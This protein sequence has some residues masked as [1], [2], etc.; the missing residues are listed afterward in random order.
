VFVAPNI[1]GL[2]LTIAAASAGVSIVELLDAP[3][4]SPRTVVVDNADDDDD[5]DATTEGKENARFSRMMND[6]VIIANVAT[7]K[8]LCNFAIA[9]PVCLLPPLVF[10]PES[11]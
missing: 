2:T 8:L 10:L 6:E 5:D 3:Y 1:A 7:N 11:F 4:P 9:S